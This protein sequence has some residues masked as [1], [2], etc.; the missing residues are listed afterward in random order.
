MM[1]RRREQEENFG[2][3]EGPRER[4]SES[5]FFCGAGAE[6]EGVAGAGEEPGG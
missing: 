5:Y 4:V 1:M 3:M 2:H 6:S